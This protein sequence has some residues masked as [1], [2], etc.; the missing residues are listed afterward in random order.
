MPDLGWASG[1][2][3]TLRNTGSPPNKPLLWTAMVNGIPLP[4]DY[5]DAFQSPFPG[6]NLGI[7]DDLAI[8]DD[9][10]ADADE[11]E[12]AGGNPAAPPPYTLLVGGFGSLHPGGI[13]VAFGD[14]S[15]R[16][17]KNS[18]SPTVYRPP[19][20]PRR[21]RGRQRQR[22]LKGSLRRGRRPTDDLDERLQQP[23]DLLIGPD[24]DP[25]AVGTAR[26]SHQPDEDIPAP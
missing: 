16:F 25:Q 19:R 4:P 26:V 2:R 14:G 6:D 5:V 1:T 20:P 23:V 22:L 10:D 18:I 12:E 9:L 24:G 17:V 13:N 7:F 3:A 21:R 11:D 8:D 15:I